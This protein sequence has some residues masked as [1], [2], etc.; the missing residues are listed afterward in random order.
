MSW[1]EFKTLLSGIAPDTPLGRIVSIRA[2]D[3]PDIIKGFTQEQKRIRSEWRSRIAKEK[4]KEE[5]EAMYESLRK[6]FI[7][8]AREAVRKP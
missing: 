4:P 3:D 7:Q 5:A 1:M 8:M 2:E 6:A